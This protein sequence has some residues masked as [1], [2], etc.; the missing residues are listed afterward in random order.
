MKALVLC[1]GFGTRLGELTQETPKPM[2]PICGEPLLAYTLSYLARFGIKQV[3]LNLHFKGSQIREHFGDGSRWAVSLHYSYEETLLG[4]AGALLQLDSFLAGEDDFLVLYGDLLI[5]QDLDLITEFH[6][7]KGAGATLLVHKREGSNS[8]IQL[9]AER[10]ITSFVERP[11]EA[12]RQASDGSW[13]NSGLQVINRRM[14]AYIPTGRPADLPMDVYIPTLEHESIYGFPLTGYRCAIDSQQRY[15]EA[16]AAVTEG[17]YTG[18]VNSPSAS[19][20]KI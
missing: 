2:L 14:L 10:R 5:D 6:R 20:Q 16:Q 17:R 19:R 1:A 8:V 9:D 12:Q 4:T 18:H 3:A 11:T 15:L 13:I 7:A